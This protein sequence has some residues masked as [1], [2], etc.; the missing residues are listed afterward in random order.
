MYIFF[1]INLRNMKKTLDFGLVLN[2][3]F[4]SH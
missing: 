4:L 3:L 1:G 2:G